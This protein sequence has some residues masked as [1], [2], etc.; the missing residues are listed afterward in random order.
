MF[1]RITQHIPNLPMHSFIHI[2][3]HKNERTNKQTNIRPHTNTKYK[4]KQTNKQINKQTYCHTQYQYVVPALFP[5]SQFTSRTCVCAYTTYIHTHTTTQ[6]QYSLSALF[7]VASSLLVNLLPVPA[8]RTTS[9]AWRLLAKAQ[10]KVSAAIEELSRAYS[11]AAT[12]LPEDDITCTFSN[13][14]T[15]IKE[16]VSLSTETSHPSSTCPGGN[17]NVQNSADVVI[18]AESSSSN[19]NHHGVVSD[20][21]STLRSR[22]ALIQNQNHQSHKQRNNSSNINT[23]KMSVN[24][25]SGLASAV[26]SNRTELMACAEAHL[27]EA[28]NALNDAWKLV[29]L[30][31]WEAMH[32]K[33]LR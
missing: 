26:E 23:N 3:I 2:Y 30:M 5:A 31:A 25:N 19:H 4:D 17:L 20:H 22:N 24:V 11:R 10:D 32:L 33:L 1:A 28:D 9:E 12:E 27:K 7:G 14:S 13:L 18:D 8:S 6:H 21:D 16:S 15:F 29:D